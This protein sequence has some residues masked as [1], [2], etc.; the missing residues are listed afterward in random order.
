MPRDTCTHAKQVARLQEHIADQH[1]AA[2]S[3][4]ALLQIRDTKIKDSNDQLLQLRH[5][6][7]S[8]NPSV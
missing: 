7:H 2:E 1:L 4:V 6:S 8:Q 5:T 3:F